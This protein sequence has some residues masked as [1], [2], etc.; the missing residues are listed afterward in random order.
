MRAVHVTPLELRARMT[1]ETEDYLTTRLAGQDIPWPP[2][3][4][5]IWAGIG[6]GANRRERCPCGKRTRQ[7]ATEP[8][9]AS[10]RAL[11]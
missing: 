1:R 10:S 9:R 2:K 11:A 3:R 7:R 8:T 4:Y 6:Q 5:G